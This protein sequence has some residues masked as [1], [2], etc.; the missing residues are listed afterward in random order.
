MTVTSVK[1][2]SFRNLS[3]TSLAFSPGVN[4]LW[5]MN[6]QGKSNI[7]EGIYYFAR[8]RS[9]RGAKD[10]DL[11][12]F[13]RDFARAE[14]GF[15]REGA[16]KPTSL[17]VMIPQTGKKKLMRSGAPLSGPAEMLGSFRAVLFCPSHLSIVSG[18]P[19]ERRAFLDIAISQ[20]SQSYILFLSRYKKYLAERNALLKRYS[21]GIKVSREEWETYAM[22]LSSASEEICDARRKYCELLNS[23]VKEY[24]EKM[25]GG[26]E[27]PELRYTS[28]LDG[29]DASASP[30]GNASEDGETAD[31][32]SD[33]GRELLYRKLTENI[34]REAA[35][36]STLWGPH[37]DDIKITVNGRDARLFA[38][39]GQGRSIALCMKLAEGEISRRLT[40]EYP[41]FLLDDVFSELD[42]VRRAFIMEELHGRQIII[43][44]CEPSAVPAAYDGEGAKFFRV[45]GGDAAGSPE[46]EE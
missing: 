16:S 8:G 24:F 22:G 23:D 46:A 4:V 18:G 3:E 40:G 26:R 41:V 21:A 29:S 1:Y 35:A 12:M 38:S 30:H 11:I 14:I 9:F 44:S 39:Q 45:S 32:G 19:A 17:S 6:A 36:G 13:G 28:H 25:T 33:G 20:T 42:E 37:K 34:E 7:L 43:T 31:T 15:A 2:Q 27:T 10:R 5:G